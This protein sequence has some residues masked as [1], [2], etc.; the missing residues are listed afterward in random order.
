[1]RIA[2]LTTQCPFV[3]GGAELHADNLMRALREVGHEVEIVTMPFKWYPAAT[4]LDHM[5]AA[6]SLDV[7]EFNGVKIDLAICLKFPA[8]LMRH[9]NKVFWILHQQRQAYDLWDS[10]HTDLF[11]GPDGQI[12]REAIRQADN[13]E[14]GSAPRI[15]ANSAN[16]AGRLLRYNNINAAPLYHPPPLAERLQRGDFGRY[17]YYPSRLSPSKRQDFVLRSLAHSKCDFRVVFSGAPDNP[18]YGRELA[19]LAQDLGVAD[20]VEW[21]GFVSANEMIELYAGARGVLFTPVDEDLGYIALEAMLAGKPLLTLSDAGEPAALVRNEIEGFV[22]P[23]EPLAFAEAMDRLAASTDLA[24]AMGDAGLKRYRALDISWTQVIAKLTNTGARTPAPVSS[25]LASSPPVRREQLVSTTATHGGAESATFIR[26]SGLFAGVGEPESTATPYPSL[27]G[28]AQRYAFDEHLV[29]HRG[30]YET[31]W[32]RYHKSLEIIARSKVKPR[33]ILELGTSAP[34]VFTALLKEAFPNAEF[35]AV[36]ESPP[37]LR[38]RHEIPGKTG[39]A[40]NVDVAVFG[41]NAE[42][43]CLPFADGEFD[44]VV[45][46]EVVEHF[47]IDP[48]FAFHEARRVLGEGGV[49]LVTTP[50]LISIQGLAR[51]LDGG[52]PYSFGTFVPW[53]GAYGRH[54]REYTPAEVESLGRYAGFDTVLLDTAD[55]YQQNEVPAA[56]R[57]YM[58][59]HGHPLDQRGQNVFYL[60]RKAADIMPAPHPKSLFSVDPAIFSG[61]LE[62]ERARELSESVIVRIVNRSRLLWRCEGA[63]RVRLTVDRVD[64]NGLVALD[65]LAVDLPRDV[66]PGGVAEI[67]FKVVASSVNGCWYEIGLYAEG[68]G[69]FK[70]AGR[71]RTVCL[72]AERLEAAPALRL[73]DDAA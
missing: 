43:T 18:D 14:L 54:N 41:L 66:E 29:R 34:Y 26:P 39:C 27:E 19:R 37:G 28:L 65:V 17:F 47:A 70:G 59:E 21:K 5:L 68:A 45:A 62:I 61:A 30:Y 55:V 9:P 48:S 64:Q 15:F 11:D 73:D 7:S 36:Q 6:R 40:P 46:M 1:M 44:L 60:G 63:A 10:G 57:G 42:T 71:A 13:V 53:N 50:N 31:H 4:I 33:R 8:Y 56:L 67:P 23:P 24:R 25:H 22:V 20:R 69:P 12:V 32:P 52:S 49:F 16:V 2:I 51:A 72:F 58:A 38:W 3:T 35:T